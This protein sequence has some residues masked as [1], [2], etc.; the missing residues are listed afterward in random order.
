MN[1]FGEFYTLELR[2]FLLSVMRK[3]TCAQVMGNIW[4]LLIQ[5]WGTKLAPFC[6]RRS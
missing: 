2:Y 6:G 5:T 4:P 1:T 3:K